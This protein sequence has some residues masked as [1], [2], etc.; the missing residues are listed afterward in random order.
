M[1]ITKTAPAKRTAEHQPI[2][3]AGLSKPAAADKAASRTAA[4]GQIRIEG[5]ARDPIIAFSTAFQEPTEIS[6]KSRQEMIRDAAYFHAERRGFAEGDPVR[7]WTEAEAE[8]D[9]M[10]QDR[11]GPIVRE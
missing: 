8:I 4:N 9:R 2:E 6:H 1:V 11:P 10:L 5:S 7:D 3:K